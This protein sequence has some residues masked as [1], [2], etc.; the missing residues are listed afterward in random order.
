MKKLFSSLLAATMVAGMAVSAFAYT[1]A[2]GAQSGN[3]ITPDDAD[4]A[5]ENKAYLDGTLV[6]EGQQ[7]KGGDTIYYPILAVDEDDS[8]NF[9]YANRASEVDGLRVYLDDIHGG[10]YIKDAKIVREDVGALKVE[11]KEAT[12]A[13]FEMTIGAPTITGTDL[14][15]LTIT[16]N[17]VATNIT[18]DAAITV[19]TTAEQLAAAI[20]AK[21]STVTIEGKTFTIANDGAKL[22]GTYATAGLTEITAGDFKVEAKAGTTQTG[23]VATT[24]NGKMTNGTAAIN[25]V[26]DQKIYCVAVT[27]EDYYGTVDTEVDFELQLKTRTIEY[28]SEDQNGDAP[29]SFILGQESEKL[30]ESDSIVKRFRHGELTLRIDENTGSVRLDEMD[31]GEEIEHIFLEADDAPFTF[32]VKASDQ[33]DLYLSVNTK[34]N[35]KIT[36]DNPNAQLTFVN[37]P[38]EPEFDFTGTAKF[39][40]DDP[41]EDYYL[42]EIVDDKLVDT[43]AKYNSEDETFDLR[44]RTLG[45]YVISDK[46]LDTTVVDD[47]DDNE[48]EKPVKPTTPEKEVPTGAL[49]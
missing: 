41:D 17:G 15:E 32:D 43:S 46:E 8:A 39:T 13:K 21:L 18:L 33:D 27:L 38:G 49:A 35:K 22:V 14:T 10:K 24:V 25:G 26:N 12:S 16:I 37:F 28:D 42:Y 31:D 29:M 44:T 1:D 34:A 23:T 4:F 7:V 40:V 2:A 19:D 3:G 30:S 48:T 20:A 36:V 5:L 6:G 9:K 45:S 11:A 47:K